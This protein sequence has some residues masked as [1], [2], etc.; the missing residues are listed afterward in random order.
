M[1]FGGIGV[2]GYLCY[3]SAQVFANSILFPFILSGLG[4][5]IIAAGVIYQRH[6]QALE[7]YFNQRI[8]ATWKNFL[9]K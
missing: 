7:H 3:L 1:V 2:F 9:P 5:G 4:L 8:P 6:C